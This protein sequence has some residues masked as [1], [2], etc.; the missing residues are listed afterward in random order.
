[1][2]SHGWYHEDFAELSVDEQRAVLGRSFEAL[3]KAAGAPPDRLAGAV[4]VAGRGRWSSSRR[5]GSATTGR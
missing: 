4:L 3:T 5:P 1:M 2:A